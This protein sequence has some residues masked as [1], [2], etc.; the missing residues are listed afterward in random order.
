[1]LKYA[2]VCGRIESYLDGTVEYFKGRDGVTELVS[3]VNAYGTQC[4]SESR[5]F[6]MGSLEELKEI[7][8]NKERLVQDKIRKAQERFEN[9]SESQRKIIEFLVRDG[10]EYDELTE[11][12]INRVLRGIRRHM[13]CNATF[14]DAYLDYMH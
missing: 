4:M 9:A 10:F 7:V 14:E 13:E 6:Q 1:M 2:L 3:W 11:S 5:A 12:Y 8:N